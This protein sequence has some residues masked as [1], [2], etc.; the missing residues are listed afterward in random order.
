MNN[1]TEL[2]EAMKA[3][4]GWVERAIV[5]TYTDR[6]PMPESCRKALEMAEKA[7]E[8]AETPGE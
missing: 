5:P 6:K 1:E 2:L 4:K 7:I 8:K 3:L